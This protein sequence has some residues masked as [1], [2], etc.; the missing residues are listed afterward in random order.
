MTQLAFSEP[1]QDRAACRAGNGAKAEWFDAAI[2]GETLHD[3]T[4]RQ[5][6][7]IV[8]CAVC[9]V[10]QECLDAALAEPTRDGVHA[11]YPLEVEG[12]DAA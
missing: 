9:P 10:Q 6:L 8:T 5:H 3:R 7:A 11:G 1:W 2:H 4:R 12:F